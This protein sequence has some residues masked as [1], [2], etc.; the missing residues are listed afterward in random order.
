VTPLRSYPDWNAQCARPIATWQSG[1][2]ARSKTTCSASSTRSRGF[3]LAILKAFAAIGLL[4]VAVGVYG[5][6]AYAVSRRSQEFAI[7]MALGATE[8]SVVRTVVRSGAVL[9]GAG[10]VIG[11]AAS[12]VTNEL[13]LSTVVL[14]SSET[15]ST[16]SVVAAVA[17]IAVVGLAACLIPARRASRIS[18][19]TALRQD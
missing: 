17:V 6:M 9:L 11:L 10:I 16:L 5:V 4:L 8:D 3:G 7:R 2:A 18:P 1:T 15:D 19:M 14:G 13:L 12:R